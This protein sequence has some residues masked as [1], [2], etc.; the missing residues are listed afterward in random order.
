MPERGPAC[1]LFLSSS[2]RRLVVFFTPSSEIGE[3]VDIKV[4]VEY[5]HLYPC[6]LNSPSAV[7]EERNERIW[8]AAGSL[9]S[10]HCIKF[11]HSSLYQQH[12]ARLC[13]MA[14]FGSTPKDYSTTC[15][16]VFR[17]W[18]WGDVKWMLQD[19]CV[20]L[21]CLA[22]LNALLIICCISSLITDSQNSL[23]VWGAACLMFAFSSQSEGIL[24]R[25]VFIS[26]IVG[27]LL[28][29]VQTRRVL[30]V[31]RGAREFDTA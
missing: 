22:L 26:C 25:T 3:L 2:Q 21:T 17:E 5:L 19:C 13:S 20:F 7:G 1:L 4:I 14:L 9:F 24:R 29:V 30:S 31:G 28:L 18:S 23:I 8:H 27:A 10:L 15:Y 12:S 6:C 16:T 11:S